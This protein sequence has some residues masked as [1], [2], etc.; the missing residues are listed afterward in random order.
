[1]E[2]LLERGHECAQLLHI[3][4]GL[5]LP[6]ELAGSSLLPRKPHAARPVLPV[7]GARVACDAG[8]QALA[9]HSERAKHELIEVLARTV[10]KLLYKNVVGRLECLAGACAQQVTNQ[11]QAVFRQAEHNGVVLV[12]LLERRGRADVRAHFLH[13]GL[14]LAQACG[15]WGC[16]QPAQRKHTLFFHMLLGALLVQA[17]RLLAQLLE[18][19]LV[20]ILPCEPG[21]F[22]RALRAC[23]RDQQRPH[24]PVLERVGAVVGERG[25]APR[26]RPARAGVAHFFASRLPMTRQCFIVFSVF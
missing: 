1:M 22:H 8:C 25:L 2:L 4:T 20:H 16:R 14:V 19:R 24:R 26:A 9:V 5:P 13:G 10:P 17:A 12:P 6:V 23:R 21:L 11:T 18:R 7:H 15:V 3:G